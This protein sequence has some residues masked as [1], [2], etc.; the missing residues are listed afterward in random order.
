MKAM[1]KFA[2]LAV[3][4]FSL[5]SV[6]TQA[7]DKFPADLSVYSSRARLRAF[8]AESARLIEMELHSAGFANLD[9]WGFG[10]SWQKPMNLQ[11]MMNQ[12]NYWTFQVPM[13]NPGDWVSFRGVIYTADYDELFVSYPTSVQPQQGKGG[14]DWYVPRPDLFFQFSTNGVPLKC[15]KS[16]T[17]AQVSFVGPNGTIQTI[18]LRVANGRIYLDPDYA[19]KGFVQLF[20]N[21]GNEVAYDL[22]RGGGRS[23]IAAVAVNG[24]NGNIQG[25]EQIYDQDT[26]LWSVYSQ[27]GYGENPTFEVNMTAK[28]KWVNVSVSTSEGAAPLGYWTRVMGS[29]NA[30]PAWNPIPANAP[31]YLPIYFGLGTTYMWAEWNPGDFQDYDPAYNGG[32]NP[33]PIG[34]GA[35]PA[36]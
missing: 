4:V 9:G 27:Q 23:P 7:A 16:I 29:T 1:Q 24:A 5:G 36:P 17:R 2:V 6:A 26:I 18:N 22:R 8:A 10:T 21:N 11:D 33:V 35:V 32:Y 14:G 12:L 34:K 30:A 25:Y 19:E 28:A 15:D 3:L 31:P 13:V 20:D